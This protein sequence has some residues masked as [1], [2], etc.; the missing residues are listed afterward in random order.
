MRIKASVGCFCDLASIVTKQRY[1]LDSCYA[2]SPWPKRVPFENNYC[3][4]NSTD[5]NISQLLMIIM[6]PASV[7]SIQLL[8]LSSNATNN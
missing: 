8:I 2:L 5:T 4:T 3:E 6:T 7:D 1:D